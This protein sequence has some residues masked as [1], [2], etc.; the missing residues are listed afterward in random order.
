MG[1]DITA[2]RQ[3]A[4]APDVDVD[5]DGYPVDYETYTRAEVNP[6]FPDQADGI[7]HHAIYRRGAEEHGFRAGSYSGYN[8]WRNELASLVG[9][10]DARACW[11]S[12]GPSPF[13]ELIN[14]SDCEGII[15]PKT[16]AKLARD[17]AEYDVRAS[18]VLTPW[19]YPLYQKWR[20]AFELASD[21]GFVD[22]H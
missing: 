14:F 15:G 21:G 6:D 3:A 5:L 2:Y 18:Q 13:R 8:Q 7:A 16:S 4:L 20:L 9:H 11:N 10:A 1:L 22:F 17:F 12:E 19:F